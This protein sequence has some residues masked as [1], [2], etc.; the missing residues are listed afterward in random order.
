MWI[1]WEVI[2]VIVNLDIVETTAKQVA[3]FD[4]QGYGGGGGVQMPTFPE[5]FLQF[6]QDVFLLIST[7]RFL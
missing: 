6:S 1:L 3:T 4:P 2:A 5:V 7:C